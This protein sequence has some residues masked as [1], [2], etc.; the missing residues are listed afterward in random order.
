MY[1]LL[2]I[3]AVEVAWDRLSSEGQGRPTLLVHKA[4]SEKPATSMEALGA[5][6]SIVLPL[7][8][9]T[10]RR[11]LVRL[12][13][14]HVKR[15]ILKDPLLKTPSLP[16]PCTPDP[17]TPVSLVEPAGVVEQI[18]EKINTSNLALSLVGS[19]TFVLLVTRH[20]TAVQYFWSVSR[21]GQRVFSCARLTR[22]RSISRT[23]IWTPHNHTPG[24]ER[25][26][27]EPSCLQ[28]SAHIDE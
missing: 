18:S 6:W 20:G 21:I 8:E 5:R 25:V 9:Q 14:R 12:R 16:G 26:L 15:S 10:R 17:T 4:T 7:A 23:Y 13:V 3:G 11:P 19:L 1:L 28:R 2:R 22:L 27:V 24:T